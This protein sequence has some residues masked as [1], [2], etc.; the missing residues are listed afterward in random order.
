VFSFC[1]SP[2]PGRPFW[3][4]PRRPGACPRRKY[5]NGGVAGPPALLPGQGARRLGPA[6][7]YQ[8]FA[9][10]SNNG[11]HFHDTEINKVGQKKVLALRYGDSP[12]VIDGASQCNFPEIF[13]P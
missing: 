10:I 6:P 11:V 4:R 9:V 1:A 12:Y 8:R 3:H 2:V 7:L 5:G 13:P